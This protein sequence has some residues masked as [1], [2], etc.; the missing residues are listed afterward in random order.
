MQRDAQAY[1][2]RAMYLKSVTGQ[3]VRIHKAAK[4]GDECRIHQ[5]PLLALHINTGDRSVTQPAQTS[6]SI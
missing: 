3:A 4:F 5:L 1:K 6:N 2:V